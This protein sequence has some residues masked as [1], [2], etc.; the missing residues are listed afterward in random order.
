M[1]LIIGYSYN[2]YLEGKIKDYGMERTYINEWRSYL[3]KAD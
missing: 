2:I 3:I 1:S